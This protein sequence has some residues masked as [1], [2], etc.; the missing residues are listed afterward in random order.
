MLVLHVAFA[1][2]A[3]RGMIIGASRDACSARCTEG[4]RRGFEAFKS[5]WNALRFRRRAALRDVGLSLSVG[6]GP[7][8]P[9]YLKGVSRDF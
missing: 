6:M 9:G 7:W 2:N 5:R 4:M 3:R 1:R 8:Q